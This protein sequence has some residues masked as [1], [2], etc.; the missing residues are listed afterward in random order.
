MAGILKEF[1]EDVKLKLKSKY[2]SAKWI[3]SIEASII[4]NTTPDKVNYF[5]KKGYIV[6]KRKGKIWLYNE[7]YI[8]KIVLNWW[9]KYEIG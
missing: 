5:G 8:K 7:K 1:L 6:R 3:T 2:I 4:L 9:I